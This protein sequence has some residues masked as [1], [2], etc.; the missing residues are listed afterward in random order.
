M[1]AY[2]H[3]ATIDRQTAGLCIRSNSSA[4]WYRLFSAHRLDT[5]P[6]KTFANGRWRLESLGRS[7]ARPLND[8]AGLYKVEYIS[9]AKPDT[10]TVILPKFFC[11]PVISA[12]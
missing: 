1:S 2:I 3:N 7:K 6:Y 9:G 12:R 11:W 8:G 10:E 5:R 4:D